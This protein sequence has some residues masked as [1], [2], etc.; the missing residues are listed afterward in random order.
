MSNSLP[1]S[2]T[3]K[4]IYLRRDTELATYFPARYSTFGYPEFGSLGG[5]FVAFDLE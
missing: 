4:S 5:R 2:A 3:V 1:G